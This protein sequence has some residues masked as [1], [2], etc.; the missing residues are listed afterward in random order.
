MATSAGYI[1]YITPEQATW[2]QLPGSPVWVF[3][4]TEPTSGVDVVETLSDDARRGLAAI[5]FRQLEGV[6]RTEFT[7]SGPAYPD[8]IGHLVRSLIGSDTF[9]AGTP[10][11]ANTHVFDVESMATAAGRSFQ[12]QIQ[13]DSGTDYTH[14]GC[15][16]SAMTFRFN[17]SE[18]LLTYEATIM[19]K[20]LVTATA[21]ATG[22]DATDDPLRGWHSHVTTSVGLGTGA[23]G[24][25]SE[26]EI[27]IARDADLLY[28]AQNDRFPKTLIPGLVAVTGRFTASFD[29][30]ADLD[31]YRNLT[32]EP[33]IIEWTYGTSNL[34]RSIDFEFPKA[35]FGDS[36]AEI[37][38]SANNMT[39]AYNFRGL[40]GTSS[41]AWATAASTNV[42]MRMSNE[43][44]QYV[45]AP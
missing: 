35:S 19:G 44:E 12:V 32:N 8:E 17:S 23:T 34:T 2:G 41:G 16:A 29:A 20:G 13:D 39:I 14:E 3:L 24:R 27:S 40:I 5:G 30:L 1:S 43:A 11:A 45:V 38:R 21:A 10:S 7:L 42:R 33:L 26:G 15:V 6:H 22:S 36:P 25:L 31:L 37:D 9:A 4:P 28:V 18:G